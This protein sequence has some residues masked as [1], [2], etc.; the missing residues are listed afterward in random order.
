M[1]VYHDDVISTVSPQ[2][3]HLSGNH[4]PLNHGC[5]RNSIGLKQ[6][7]LLYSIHS[8]IPKTINFQSCLKY[9]PLTHDDHIQS[10]VQSIS[11]M[12]LH[13]YLENC[14]ISFQDISQ[15]GPKT[16]TLKNNITNHNT[17][18]FTSPKGSQ[19]LGTWDSWDESPFPPLPFR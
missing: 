16:T 13:Y 9:D 18:V 7:A 12:R 3:P 4:S 10:F 1:S 17:A 8:F 14:V 19:P 6:V 15:K 5:W 2:Q 11:Y